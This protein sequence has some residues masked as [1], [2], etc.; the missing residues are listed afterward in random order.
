M[1]T[2]IITLNW[3]GTKNTTQLLQ[4]YMSCNIQIPIWVVD[5][6]SDIDD[7]EAFKEIC[8]SVEIKKLVPDF[9]ELNI[10]FFKVLGRKQP[11]SG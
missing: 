3:N 8:P 6:G 7:T 5:N 2:V 10:L 9:D 11:R 4:S 1:K